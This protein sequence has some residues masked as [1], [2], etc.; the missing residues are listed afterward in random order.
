MTHNTYSG[1]IINPIDRSEIEYIPNGALVVESGKIIFKG[2]ID[3]ALELYPNSEVH[4]FGNSIIIPGLIDL[5]THIPQLPAAGIGSGE[6][7]EWLNNYIFP[8]EAK[9]NN[10]EYAFNL[11]EHF[12]KQALKHGTTTA[13]CFASSGKTGACE[14][15][16]AAQKTG[17]KAYIGNSLIDCGAPDYL[18]YSAEKNI[19]DALELAN[20]WHDANGGKLKYILSPR[21][22]LACSIG[23]MKRAAQIA[24]A[25]GYFVQTHLSESKS[26]VQ[27]VAK[28]FPESKSYTQF[29]EQMGLLSERT[30]LAHCIH[31]T[32][33][34]IAIIKD[35]GSAI[36]HCPVSNRFLKSG[37]MPFAQ[38]QKQNLKIGLGTDVAA[39][40]SQS[41][42]HEAK[43]A[44]ECSKMFSYFTNQD[45]AIG[46]EQ[47]FYSATLGAAKI[48]KD[49]SIGSLDIGSDADFAVFQMLDNKWDSE[50]QSN[51]AVVLAKLIYGCCGWE[52]KEVYV[53]GEKLI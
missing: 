42:L 33:D 31:L 2:M 11:A 44:V 34:E 30:L 46:I 6:L 23:L 51:P 13:V 49:D 3:E 40:Y 21:Y 38:Y 4:D 1:Y 26:E 18:I 36:A 10:K 22:S 20:C 19:A 52:A 28:A 8:L 43:E 9:S 47:A 27:A 35:S 16:K 53:R 24:K 37:I 14:A 39:G 7:L 41:I 32:A 17:I 50:L 25:E 45:V 5:H 48:L 15:F 29:Y 12:F